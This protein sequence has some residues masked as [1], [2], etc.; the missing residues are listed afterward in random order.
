MGSKESDYIFLYNNK[1]SNKKWTIYTSHKKTFNKQATIDKKYKEGAIS[2]KDLREH[3][4]KQ[5]IKK[6]QN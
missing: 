3:I 6:L 4:K 5:H 2:F 1:E